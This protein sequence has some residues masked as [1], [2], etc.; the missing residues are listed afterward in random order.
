[1]VHAIGQIYPTQGL[2]GFFEPFLGRRAV[3]DE[4]Q[5]DVVK[6]RGAGQE[7]ERLKDKANFLVPNVGELIVVEFTH[8]AAGKPILAGTRR[9]ETANQVH[10]RGFS[11]A[12]RAHNRNV[13]AF[14]DF[15]I[16][17]AERVHLL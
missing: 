11:G 15:E 6:S 2:L 3:V 1:M 7:I 8:E 17:A 9:I 14:A 12:R 10:E 13:L 4:W 16:N 5:F